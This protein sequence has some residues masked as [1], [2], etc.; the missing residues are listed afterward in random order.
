MRISVSGIAWDP[1]EDDA[2]AGLLQR[3][4]VDAVDIAPGKYFPHPG[5]ATSRDVQAVKRAWQDRGI[6][7]TGM[8]ALLFG[9][10][11]LNLFGTNSARAAMLAHLQGLCRIAGGLEARHL[12][13][14]SPKN[15]DRRGLDEAAAIDIAIGFFRAL[16]DAAAAEG[17]DVCLEPNPS[18]YGCNFMTTGEETAAVV[19]AVGHPAIRMQLDTGAVTMNGEDVEL[20]LSR[21]AHLVGHVHASEPHLVPLGDGGTDHVAM[22][23]ALARHLPRAV[24]CIEMV[25][26]TAEPH[27]R[28][29]DRALGVAISSYRGGPAG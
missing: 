20:L 29:I 21:H 25:A 24:V 9:T 3:H 26:T 2:V 11:G 15:R 5:A 7:L 8:Q 10:T 1:A 27:L 12:V 28:S 19:A 22:N 14:G 4:G 16:G 17:V 6:E 23:G 18:S 13:F